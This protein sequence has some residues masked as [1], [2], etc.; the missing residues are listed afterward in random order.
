MKKTPNRSDITYDKIE[1][2]LPLT[3]REWQITLNGNWCS[4][5]WHDYFPN[6]CKEN[7]INTKT[8]KFKKALWK[9]ISDTAGEAYMKW[10]E[11]SK[12]EH[13]AI[14]NR[15]FPKMMKAVGMPGFYNK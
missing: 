9:S 15:T 10:M 6:F 4:A 14:F 12:A 13:I 5:F 2:D 1:K 7:G 11:D 3:F 8:A